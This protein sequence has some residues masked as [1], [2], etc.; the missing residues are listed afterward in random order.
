MKTGFRLSIFWESKPPSASVAEIFDVF[1]G[2]DSR[3]DDILSAELVGFVPDAPA[4]VAGA[5]HC[6][7]V[8]AV[9]TVDLYIVAVTI[10]TGFCRDVI[11]SLPQE[12]KSPGDLGLGG[13]FSVPGPR[14]YGQYLGAF[15]VFEDPAPEAAT[16]PGHVDIAIVGKLG[17]ALNG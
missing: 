7:H 15:V 13:S 2:F 11:H 1:D 5:C 16:L 14:N 8:C 4:F 6:H 17:D 9:I 3:F 12:F 10:W